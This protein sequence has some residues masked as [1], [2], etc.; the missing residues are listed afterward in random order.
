MAQAPSEIVYIGDRF[1][2]IDFT[3]RWAPAP[4]HRLITFQDGAVGDGVQG[5][6]DGFDGD[7]GQS[8]YSDEVLYKGR[9]VC[10][11]FL[12]QGSVGQLSFGGAVTSGVRVE[13]GQTVWI[14]SI[15]YLPSSFDLN[16]SMAGGGAMKYMRQKVTNDSYS[17]GHADL[18]IPAPDLGLPG[19][20]KL[21]MEAHTSQS[22]GH[23]TH[24]SNINVGNLDDYQLPRDEFVEVQ[25]AVT[26][27]IGHYEESR[28]VARVWVG[29][30]LLAE[31]RDFHTMIGDTDY[32][33][34]IRLFGYFNANYN[35]PNSPDYDPNGGEHGVTKDM[36]CYC[37][38]F[39]CTTVEPTYTDAFGNPKLPTR[40]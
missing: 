39:E 1:K 37:A 35:P 31:K 5:M 32:C 11:C 14:R 9:Q 34:V 8:T 17:V 4:F 36:H 28:C 19:P 7:A 13:R 30:T 3:S 23:A 24:N 29:D 12:P 33:D 16:E 10:K 6:P 21:V 18:Y 25:Y 20:F 38:E 2:F 22:Q 26:H 40:L 15:I 27:D